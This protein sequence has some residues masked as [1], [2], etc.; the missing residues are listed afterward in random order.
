MVLEEE[1][2]QKIEII[3]TP[4]VKNSLKDNMLVIQLC[5]AERIFKKN[6]PK[7][8][9]EVVKKLDCANSMQNFEIEPFNSFN[10]SK[11][12]ENLDERQQFENL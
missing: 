1:N 2:V 4:K 8:F 3:D 6:G 9:T 11:I 12:K 7:I 10:K 5:K